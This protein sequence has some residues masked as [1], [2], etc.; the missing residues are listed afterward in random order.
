MVKTHCLCSSQGTQ[1]SPGTWGDSSSLPQTLLHSFTVRPQPGGQN[2][3]EFLT[4]M[5]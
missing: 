3:K 5:G 2:L 4:R 1:A